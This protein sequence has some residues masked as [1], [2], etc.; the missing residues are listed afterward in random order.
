[1]TIPVSKDDRP[2]RGEGLGSVMGEG[3]GQEALV[4]LPRGCSQAG[5]TN[6][7]QTKQTSDITPFPI[8]PVYLPGQSLLAH[9][10]GFL[11]VGRGAPVQWEGPSHAHL[12]STLG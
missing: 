10:G 4:F 8:H 6:A 11:P 5:M 12:T 2:S 1:M 7:G 3:R 9:P